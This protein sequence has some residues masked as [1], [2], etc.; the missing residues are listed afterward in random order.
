MQKMPVAVN[1]VLS[2]PHSTWSGS[3]LFRTAESAWG[4]PSWSFQH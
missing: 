2:L 1:T 4:K 3:S